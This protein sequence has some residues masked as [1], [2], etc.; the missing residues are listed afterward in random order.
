MINHNADKRQTVLISD[1]Q[2]LSRDTSR[3]SDGKTEQHDDADLI[4]HPDYE[5][6]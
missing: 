6:M 4:I 1:I 3:K 2:Q 5:F